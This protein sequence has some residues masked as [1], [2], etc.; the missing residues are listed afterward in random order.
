LRRDKIS[1]LHYIDDVS[2]TVEVRAIAAADRKQ[3]P[4]KV[5][6]RSASGQMQRTLPFQVSKDNT[7]IAVRTAAADETRC[8][9]KSTRVGSKYIVDRD[10]KTERRDLMNT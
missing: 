10:K 9:S 6:M 7:L 4:L 5:H 1:V 8:R 2:T 3:I